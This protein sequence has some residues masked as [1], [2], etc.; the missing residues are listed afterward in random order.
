[1][2]GDKLAIYTVHTY[3]LQRSTFYLRLPSLRPTACL[4]F[5]KIEFK[6]QSCGNTTTDY[7]TLRPQVRVITKDNTVHTDMQG[8]HVKRRNMQTMKYFNLNLQQL[9]VKVHVHI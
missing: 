1:M 7:Y 4:D 3:I 5:E 9:Q 8:K 2:N 6:W